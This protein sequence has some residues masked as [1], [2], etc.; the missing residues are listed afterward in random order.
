MSI[1]CWLSKT[2][3]VNPSADNLFSSEKIAINHGYRYLGG[4]QNRPLTTGGEGG[5]GGMIIHGGLAAATGKTRVCSFCP[6]LW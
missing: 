6:V 2:E 4:V 3:H 1:N 5:E